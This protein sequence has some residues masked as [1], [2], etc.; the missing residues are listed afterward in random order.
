MNCALAVA[1]IALV[2]GFELSTELAAAYGIAVTGTMAITSILFYR[3][4]ATRWQWP[5][6]QRAAASSP[7]SS[8]IDLAFLSAQRVKL[9]HGGWFP[10]VVAAVVFI[11]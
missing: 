4:R 7:S 11:V 1:C 6:W 5:R 3:G 9:A 2:L 8:L 10:L